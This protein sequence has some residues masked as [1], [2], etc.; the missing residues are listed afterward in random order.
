ME[1]QLVLLQ[2]IGDNSQVLPLPSWWPFDSRLLSSFLYM[3]TA[4]F[5]LRLSLLVDSENDAISSESCRG[6][7]YSDFG[8]PT[9]NFIV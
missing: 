2:N 4:D 9:I 5:T 1:N 6:Q 3:A 8:R 7:M